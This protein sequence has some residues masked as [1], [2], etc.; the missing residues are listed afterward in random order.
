[1]IIQLSSPTNHTKVKADMNSLLSEKD[2]KAVLTILAQELDVQEAQLT[3]DA[4]LTEDL[5]ADSLTKVEIALALEERFECSIP[6][7]ELEKVSTVGN[8]FEALAELLATRQR[9]PG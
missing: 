3:L 4:S 6:D 8:L 9:P 1:M 5:G 7:E 2:T